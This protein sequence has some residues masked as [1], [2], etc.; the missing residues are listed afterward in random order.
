MQHMPS[1][2]EICEWFVSCWLQ[3]VTL[4]KISGLAEEAGI[5]V[6]TEADEGVV[7][8]EP[9]MADEGD[10]KPH[11]EE[12]EEKEAEVSQVSSLG[13]CFLYSII[14]KMVYFSWFGL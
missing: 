3:M 9:E 4:T 5:T 10:K 6:V 2:A 11:E 1:V 13:R 8:P 7:A 12:E 14:Q